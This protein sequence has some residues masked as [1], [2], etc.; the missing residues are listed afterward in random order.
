M[1]WQQVCGPQSLLILFFLSCKYVENNICPKELQRLGA[2]SRENSPLLGRTGEGFP[3]EGLIFHPALLPCCHQPIKGLTPS[4]S[5]WEEQIRETSKGKDRHTSWIWERENMETWK[6]QKTPN[7]FSLEDQANGMSLIEKNEVE[8]ESCF[9]QRKLW[10]SITWVTKSVRMNTQRERCLVAEIWRT[11]RAGG[12]VGKL[13]VRVPEGW[14]IDIICHASS[15]WFS[16]SA[17]S[18]RFRRSLRLCPAQGERVL[19]LIIDV[20]HGLGGAQWYH[21]FVFPS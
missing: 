10:S 15:N 3:T 9:E 5:R 2:Q 17:W 11:F 20:C 6:G 7:F 13:W 14:Q 4:L 1:I 12:G 16:L 21:A 18:A 8:N 19:W